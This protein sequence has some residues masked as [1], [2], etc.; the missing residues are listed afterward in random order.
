MEINNER[1]EGSEQDKVQNSKGLLGV[2]NVGLALLAAIIP[3]G[4][5]VLGGASAAAGAASAAAATPA[6]TNYTTN[7]Q[8]IFMAHCAGCH[9][10]ERH[11]GGLVIVTK[12]G[13][14]K[15]GKDGAVIVPGDPANSLLVK[16]IKHESPEGGPGPMPPMGE[17]LSD[18]DV[19]TIEQWIKDGAVMPDDP[20]PAAMPDAAPAAK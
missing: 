10:A 16:L 18:A 13:L 12:A 5:V 4:L 11:R 17:K 9:S 1:C 6:E 14:L 15:G 20:A 3:A 2:R 7:V 8:P 19:A